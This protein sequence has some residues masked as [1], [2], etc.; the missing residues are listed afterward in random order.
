[1]A[2]TMGDPQ[3]IGPEII[4]KALLSFPVFPSKKIY[5]IGALSVFEQVLQFSQI[6]DRGDVFFKNI[7]EKKTTKL[8][9]QEAGILA[10]RALEEAVDLLK[11]GEVSSLVTAPICKKHMQLAGFLFP[12]HTEYLC[13]RFQ[14]QKS[15]MML[16][17]DKLRVV[18]VT[19]HLPLK[20]IFAQITQERIEEKLELTAQ[21]LVSYFG[22]PSPKIAV[23]G[24][25]P[26]GGEQGLL[27]KEEQEIIEPAIQNF[28]RSRDFS[29]VEVV[30]PVSADVVFYQALYGKYDAVLCHYHDQALIPL[31][32]SGFEKGVNMTLGLPFLRTSP[33]H[34]VAFDIAGKNKA[35]PQSMIAAIEAVQ[36]PKRY[37][38]GGVYGRN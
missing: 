22:I 29:F 36:E 32:T 18:L 35:N 21:A 4:V 9:P 14:I 27:G 12:G 20:N 19:T 34:G 16:F 15:A 33:D 23:C 37:K 26:H 5:L 2:L 30:G 38:R 24:L 28:Q 3:G 11:A 10:F 13:D 31:K 7:E 1:M 25:N 8:N 17:H 6:F